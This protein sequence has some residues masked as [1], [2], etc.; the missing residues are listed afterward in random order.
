MCLVLFCARYCVG[1]GRWRLRVA[2]SGTTGA[3]FVRSTGCYFRG[4]NF[5][6]DSSK[7]WVYPVSI[8]ADT[9]DVSAAMLSLVQLRTQGHKL[10]NNNEKHRT[11]LISCSRRQGGVLNPFKT[12]PTFL[13]TTSYYLEMIIFAVV[14]NSRHRFQ[15]EAGYTHGTCWRCTIFF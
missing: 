1:G 15:K 6:K 8:S 14:K 9:S 2:T 10:C 11:P 13:G 3:V 5:G 7:T 4:T 12:A